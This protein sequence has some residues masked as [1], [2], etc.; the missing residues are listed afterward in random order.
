MKYFSLTL[1]PTVL[2]ALII[3]A[4]WDHLWP[5]VTAGLAFVWLA[6]C[7]ALGVLVIG[8]SVWRVRSTKEDMALQ[9]VS[10]M[11]ANQITPA[12]A[13]ST[14]DTAHD[15]KIAYLQITFIGFSKDSFSFRTLAPYFEANSRK[16]WD[17]MKEQ[18]IAAGW[19]TDKGRKVGMIFSGSYRRFSAGVRLGRIVLLPHPELPPP[20]VRWITQGLN[21][22]STSNTANT[23]GTL[24]KT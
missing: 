14:P 17:W 15:W 7:I 23:L 22:L 9:A 18:L 3:L 19:V 6:L 12:P 2:L 24:T 5:F 16:Y 8:W 13:Q 1:W 21:T 10:S 4:A 20:R 11:F